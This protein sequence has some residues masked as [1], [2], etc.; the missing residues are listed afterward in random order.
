MTER[1]QNMKKMTVENMVLGMMRTN[2]YLAI[3]SETKEGLI[4]DPADQADWIRERIGELGMK[5]VAVLLTH[6]HFDH[7]GAA[8]ALR[9]AYGIPV[10]AHE[11]EQEVLENPSL[12]LSE[13]FGRLLMV[14]A[15][16]YVTEKEERNLAGR[17]ILALHTP[18]HTQGGCCY[19][20]PEEEILFSGDTLFCESM[21]RT[22]F[23]TGNAGEL[24][25]SLRRLADEL[26]ETTVVYPGHEMQTD[27]AHEKSYNPFLIH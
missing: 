18:G 23:P 12:N 21:G 11:R 10:I 22:D 27:L 24:A 6:G 14:K 2:C 3:N 1:K 9:R 16:Q 17:R 20:L 25:R 26:P 15:D 19:Y 4:V 7:I 8:D 5:P 13:S